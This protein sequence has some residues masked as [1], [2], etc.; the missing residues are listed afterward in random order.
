MWNSLLENNK[1]L[2][3]LKDK[4]NKF[5]VTVILFVL[6]VAFYICL[7]FVQK[8]NAIFELYAKSVFPTLASFF[9][10]LNGYYPF[11]LSEIFLIAAAIF[12]LFK[13]YFLI[14]DIHLKKTTI[15]K[16]ILG[17]SLNVVI[18]ASIVFFLFYALWG[19][20]YFRIS[21][22]HKISFDKKKITKQ[23][24]KIYTEQFIN[25]VNY[26]Y[27]N[28]GN[29]DL[30]NISK[31][32]NASMK[33]FIYKIDG[34]YVS[35][36]VYVKQPMLSIIFDK[37]NVMGVI[38][39]LLIEAHCTSSL[40][41]AEFPFVCAHEKSHT[42]GYANESEADFLAFFTCILSDN[43]YCKYSGYLMVLFKFLS[44]YRKNFPD[45]Y[46]RLYNTLDKGVRDD[47][48]IIIER[49]KKNEGILSK[50]SHKVYDKMLKFN[51]ISEGTESYELVVKLILATDYY[52]REIE[53]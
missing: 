2:S 22:N 33:E 6:S 17:L 41:S 7:L 34:I 18:T 48:R 5:Y 26:F 19:F 45:D 29:F 42:A 36:P 21:L 14:R 32:I 1:F 25:K 20:N 8:E 39:P 51:K 15:G 46:K 40:T 50:L 43:N 53:K 27:N 44:Q 4:K 30:L 24:L 49:I 23:N 35:L 31:S 47:I 52:E 3:V 13:L 11:S 9:I 12:F 38:N 37:M 16:V 10:F 28:K